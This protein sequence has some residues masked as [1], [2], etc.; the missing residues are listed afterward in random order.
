L[1]RRLIH[2]VSELVKRIG[3]PLKFMEVCGTHTMA[4]AK[5]GLR[6]V[7][8][9]DLELLSGPGCP[10]CVTANSDIDTMIALARQPGLTICSFGDMLR[11]PG[12]TSSLL[13]L[14]AEGKDIQIV[15]SPLD[16]LAMA[17]AE[18]KRQVVFVGVGFE[19]TTPIVAAAIQRAAAR[20]LANF[21]VLALHKRV[22][23]ALEV[24]LNDA[25]LKLDALILPGHVSTILGVE[26]YR[27]ISQRWQMPAV[28]TGFEPLDILEGLRELLLLV[29]AKDAGQPIDVHNAYRRG[30]SDSG[31]L[32]A[33]AAIDEV[34]CVAD[35]EW[36]GLGMINGSG[37]RLRPEFA[38]FDALARF[39]PEVEPTREVLGCLCGD[40]L[41]G[42][43]T[44]RG[45]PHFGRS[46]LPQ[47]PL[48][49]CMVSS[50]GSCAAYY[51]YQVGS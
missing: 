42:R 45:C 22:P 27:F 50:E 49:P 48:G 4:I 8:P 3:R 12:S 23:P 1:A 24:L 39:A 29:Q 5:T 6:S 16:S 40:V 15:Y 35:A 14:R 44:P 37:Y 11:V 43:I 33:L 34:F 17:A 7:L 30:A 31:N 32:A 28:I 18:T 26:P 20:G 10:V 19:T 21:S 46:C 47:S 41:R 25:E 36:R 38:R 2:Q 13:E 51:R 9:A